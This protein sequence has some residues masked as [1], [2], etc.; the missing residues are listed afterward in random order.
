VIPTAVGSKVCSQR[1][2]TNKEQKCIQPISDNHEHGRDG[3]VLLD[4]CEYKIEEG[5]HAEHSDEDHIIDDGRVAFGS[6]RDYIPVK[7]KYEEG[8]EKLCA[9]SQR[10]CAS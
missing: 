9:T 10:C 7:R 1:D 8:K 4:G 2:S 3:E 5:E 6:L